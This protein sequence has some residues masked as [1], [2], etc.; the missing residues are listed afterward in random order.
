ME[1]LHPWIKQHSELYEQFIKNYNNIENIIIPNEFLLNDL[2]VS[3]D[4]D[5]VK[6]LK[7]FQYWLCKY[8]D[9]IIYYALN[10]K[11]DHL[12]DNLSKDALYKLYDGMIYYKC[13]IGIEEVKKYLYHKN[14][15][16]IYYLDEN[17]LIQI[18]CKNNNFI[19]FDN[20]L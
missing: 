4:N 12:Y 3:N 19:I 9:E 5:F 8:N 15:K 7:C 13:N 18:L 14:I 10:N 17:N 20:V 16:N 1:I 2:S 6:V 11:V